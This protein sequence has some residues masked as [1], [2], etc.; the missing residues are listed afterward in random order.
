MSQRFGAFTLH[1]DRRQLLR[2]GRE[3]HL[4][5]KAFDLLTLL[6]AHAPAVVPKREI[7]AR[8]WP[9]TFVSDATLVGLV[10]EV[11]RA[12]NDEQQG[13]VIRT[14]HRVGYAFAAS[15]GVALSLCADTSRHLLA[16]HRHTPDPV[17]RGNPCDRAR[18]LCDGV[19]RRR[20]C[21]AAPRANHHPRW[22]GVSGGSREQERHARRGRADSP[23]GGIAGRGSHSTRHGAPRLPHV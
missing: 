10:K 7:H 6:V 12:L 11:R 2:D 14:A 9:D 5:P 18:S 23:A 22:C 17:A 16:G 3:V 19:P 15:Q 21:F 13:T 20:W 4:T 1:A 8:L